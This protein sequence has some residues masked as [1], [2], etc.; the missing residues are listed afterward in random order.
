MIIL[1]L[2]VLNPKIYLAQ[3]R[4]LLLLLHLH[5]CLFN[6]IGSLCSLTYLVSLIFHWHLLYRQVCNDRIWFINGVFLELSQSFWRFSHWMSQLDKF[7]ILIVCSLGRLV[8]AQIFWTDIDCLFNVFEFLH[9]ISNTWGDP[10]IALLGHFTDL[11]RKSL[12]E[13]YRFL[14][15]IF[16]FFQILGA[17]FCRICRLFLKILLLFELIDK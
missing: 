10:K 3:P 17:I 7:G 11:T 6:Y 14:L 13:I 5:Q 12:N 4:L 16:S 9:W 1:L 8:L 15:W 2:V